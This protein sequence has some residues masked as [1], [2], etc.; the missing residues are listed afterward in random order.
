M[1]KFRNNDIV[2]WTKEPGEW[3]VKN[4]FHMQR[5]YW[6]QLGLED[7]TAKLALEDDLDLIRRP[8]PEPDDRFYFL[9]RA[10]RR[11]LFQNPPSTGGPQIGS[12]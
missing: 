9:A 7:A 12:R 4:E 8:E 10:I 6:I 11:V 2:S 5:K 1:A 3:T